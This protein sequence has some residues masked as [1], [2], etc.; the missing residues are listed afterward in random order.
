[1][2]LFVAV[3]P[4]EE[5]RAHLA[6]ALPDFPSEARVVPVA[7]WHLTLAFLDEVADEEVDGV[8]RAVEVAAGST[9][10]FALQLAG[11]GAFGRE[12]GTVW[13]GLLG[14]T[15]RLAK[16]ERVLRGG[17]VAIGIQLES[18]PFLPHLTLARGVDLRKPAAAAAVAELTSYRGPEWRVDQ[19][20]LVH[21]RLGSSGPQ[22]ETIGSWPLKQA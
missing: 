20:V 15:D 22:H 4:P 18:R 13:V 1:V 6:T 17:L 16:L 12:R 5:A 2:R 21:S 19:L 3:C 8:R 10:P 14:N 9:R 11:A 7:Q